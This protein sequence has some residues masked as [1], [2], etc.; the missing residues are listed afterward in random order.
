MEYRVEDNFL[1]RE[2]FEYIKNSIVG[3]TFFPWYGG[4]GVSDSNS[5]DGYYFN[6][7]LYNNHSRISETF[8]LVIPIIQKINPFAIHRIKVNFYPSTEK[9]IYHD[10]HIDHD[11]PHKGLIFYLN[12]NDGKTILDDGTE[13]DSVE[14]RVLFFDPSIRHRSTNCT[15]HQMG[16]YNINFNYV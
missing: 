4:Y 7:I 11:S 12:T 13:I 6:H 8:D 15:N 10:F 1:P 16:R 2:D 14:N 3:N 5:N 9:L